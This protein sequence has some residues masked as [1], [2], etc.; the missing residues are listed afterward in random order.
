M[1]LLIFEDRGWTVATSSWTVGG[2][3]NRGSCRLIYQWG[4]DGY[5]WTD[6]R[7]STASL[8]FDN[9]SADQLIRWIKTNTTD[10]RCDLRTAK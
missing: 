2:K 1:T 9:M 8:A 4:P 10:G 7:V 3:T 5:S 6:T